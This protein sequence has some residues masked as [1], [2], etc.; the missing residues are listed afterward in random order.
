MIKYSRPTIFP[1]GSRK[2]VPAYVHWRAMVN[3]CKDDYVLEYPTYEGCENHWLS[4]ED[5]YDWV[6]NQKGYGKRDESGVLY[7]LD[8]DLLVSGNLVYSSETCVILPPEI[9]RFLVSHRVN[10]RKIPVGIYMERGKFRAG[11]SNI[12]LG[13]FDTLVEAISAY[14]K[15][16][17]D[18]AKSLAEKWVDDID[19]RAYDSLINY[20]IRQYRG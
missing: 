9:N 5:F 20:R 15:A 18:Q 2:P 19:E 3:R 10:D 4:Y 11:Y 8:K 16:R 12:N 17:K 6:V 7:N 13:R 1:P 14:E